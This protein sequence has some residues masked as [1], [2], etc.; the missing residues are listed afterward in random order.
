MT[1]DAEQLIDWNGPGTELA[2]NARWQVH[3]IEAEYAG[4]GEVRIEHELS[5]DVST[6]VTDATSEFGNSLALPTRKSKLDKPDT[7]IKR[8]F[9]RRHEA[10]FPAVVRHRRDQVVVWQAQGSDYGPVRL[11]Q[12]AAL[13]AVGLDPCQS[14]PLARLRMTVEGVNFENIQ[15]DAAARHRDPAAADNGMYAELFAKFTDKC[16]F[17]TFAGFDLATGKFPEAGVLLAFGSPREQD[18]PI[19]VAQDACDDMDEWRLENLISHVHSGSELCAA[20]S[21]L[22][23][24]AHAA[25]DQQEYRVSSSYRGTA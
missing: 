17:R 2:G 5:P 6:S 18:S 8:S 7:T 14:L 10:G 12:L 23:A 13:D 4:Q 9:E 11:R 20:P 16:H 3:A 25:F 1:G 21:R 19:R 24:T 22:L 15:Q